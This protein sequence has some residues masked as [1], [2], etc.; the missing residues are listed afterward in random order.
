VRMIAGG[1]ASEAM[2]PAPIWM[3]RRTRA[4]ASWTP[5]VI[6]GYVLIV[7]LTMIQYVMDRGVDALTGRPK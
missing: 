3:Q 5:T 4:L 7:A 2:P 6:G 1:S